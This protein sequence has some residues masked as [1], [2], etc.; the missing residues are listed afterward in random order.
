MSN[1]AMFEELTWRAIE[2]RVRRCDIAIIPFGSLEIQPAHLPLG[3]DTYIIEGLVR[4][5]VSLVAEEVGALVLPPFDM[6]NPGGPNIV[7]TAMNLPWDV[8]LDLLVS[9]FTDLYR[10]GFRRF[11]LVNGHGSTGVIRQTMM[12]ADEDESGVRM[13]GEGFSYQTAFGFAYDAAAQFVESGPDA[14]MFFVSIGG[15]YR[16]MEEVTSFP[17][18]EAS[19]EGDLPMQAKTSIML[20]LQPELV[21]LDAM[22]GNRPLQS[23]YPF[24][25][26][27]RYGVGAVMNQNRYS[28]ADTE[29]PIGEVSKEIGEQ[30]IDIWANKFAEML[31]EMRRQN[32][33]AGRYRPDAYKSDQP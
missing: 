9:I 4:R 7:P 30:L 16:N 19:G 11:V 12:E 20:A 31:R 3:T 13:A 6:G 18:W 25:G 26:N 24:L 21:N 33:L 23:D 10:Q 22:R 8:L 27:P 28:L 5:G 1:K 15:F 2:E 32:H 29:E 14:E 17:W